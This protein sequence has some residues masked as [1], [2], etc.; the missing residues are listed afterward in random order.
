M[1][2][3]D[4]KIEA[5]NVG[6][7]QFLTVLCILTFIGCA[8]G[9][10]GGAISIVSYSFINSAMNSQEMNEAFS[11]TN[12]FRSSFGLLFWNG[13]AKIVGALMCLFGAILMFKLKKIGFYIYVVGQIV[14]VSFDILNGLSSLSGSVFSVLSIFITLLFPVVFIALY[15]LNFKHLK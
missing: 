2:L 10:I 14:A 11:T 12:D 15:G 1:D 13:V 8:M 4:E 5:V 9:I 7:P 6:R 3:L